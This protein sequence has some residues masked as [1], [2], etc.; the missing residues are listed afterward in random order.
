MKQLLE[1][2]LYSQS[3]G[4]SLTIYNRCLGSGGS[5]GTKL[6]YGEIKKPKS[7]EYLLF[8]ELP[9]QNYSLAYLFRPYIWQLTNSRLT[10]M[11]ANSIP[12]SS[13]ACNNHQPKCPKSN[14]SKIQTKLFSYSPTKTSHLVFLFSRLVGLAG[15]VV[16]PAPVA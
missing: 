2:R 5:L 6:H 11:A 3:K 8:S 1:F 12:N 15:C 10:A 4:P 13:S 7:P 9:K 16:G 14:L